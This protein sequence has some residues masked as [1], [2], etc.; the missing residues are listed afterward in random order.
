[1]VTSP[2]VLLI[3]DEHDIASA[4]SRELQ[5]RGVTV[6]GPVPSISEA[7]ANLH[8]E[9]RIEGAILDLNLQGEMA[10]PVA[11]ALVEQHIPFIIATGYGG[12]HIPAKYRVIPR[13]QKPF[14]PRAVVGLWSRLHNVPRSVE[15]PTSGNE[16]LGTLDRT[17]MPHV[18]AMAEEVQLPKGYVVTL[19][20]GRGTAQC[21][22]LNS[23]VAVCEGMNRKRD[24]VAVALVGREGVIGLQKG[25]AHR[26]PR[27]SF[28]MA[29]G[30]RGLRIAR[31]KL[32]ELTSA[33]PALTDAINTFS[34][35]FL[36]EIAGNVISSSHDNIENRVAQW[37]FCL[38]EKARS[39]NLSVTHEDIALAL[40]VRR[41]GITVALNQLRSRGCI[42]QGRAEI[43]VRN[44]AALL[45]NCQPQL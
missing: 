20:D 32:A 4:I 29:V 11:D 15:E 41:P 17:A 10:Y 8:G 22:F 34:D 18:L 16:I 6:V 13:I 35:N 1:M 12:E 39:L 38:S 23:G 31:H 7:M 3:E 42:T 40:G 26:W 45:A 43:R 21:C 24:V 19:N 5:E 14:E 27:L 36:G 37:L 33:S 25:D 2:R 30:G 44:K 9:R 28:R